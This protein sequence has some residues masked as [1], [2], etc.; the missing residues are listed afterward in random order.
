MGTDYSLRF[1]G[2]RGPE[3]E[4]AQLVACLGGEGVE[5]R[6]GGLEGL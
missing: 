4:L 6:L 1:R 3:T 2:A 5:S